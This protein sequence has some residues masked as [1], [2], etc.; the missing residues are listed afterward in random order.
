MK[1]K[2]DLPTAPPR[3]FY[4]LGLGAAA[5]L[6]LLVALAPLVDNETSRPLALFAHD[7]TLRRT[8]LASAAG[9]VVTACVFFRAPAPAE[10]A[11]ASKTPRQP[12]PAKIVGA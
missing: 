3:V 9:L 6:F 1:P 4:W 7:V 5:L 2:Y 10:P 8:T 12:P 11:P